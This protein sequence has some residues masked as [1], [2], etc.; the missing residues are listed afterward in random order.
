MSDV[1]TQ[2]IFVKSNLSYL[3]LLYRYCQ[4]IVHF[5]LVGMLSFTMPTFGQNLR[6]NCPQMLHP[7]S[8]SRHYHKF[9]RHHHNHHHHCHLTP[10]RSSVANAGGRAFC[11][12]LGMGWVHIGQWIFSISA[13]SH[14]LFWR[15]CVFCV[16]TL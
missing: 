5:C 1:Q 3:K 2:T 10:R 15:N 14:E 8:L 12:D 6:R 9:H 11:Q 7:Q 4:A 16:F 13:I